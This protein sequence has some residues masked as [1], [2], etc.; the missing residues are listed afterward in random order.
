MRSGEELEAP[1]ILRN[2]VPVEALYDWE[3]GR[4]ITLRNLLQRHGY[5]SLE[6][7]RAEGGATTEIETLR[8]S[9]LE[10]LAARSLD[11]EDDCRA[12]IGSC[13]NV[14]VLTRWL[15]RAATVNSS[16]DVAEPDED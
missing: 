7:V 5:D 1:G 2:P 13:Q 14:D 8:R 11:A 16:A 3:V 15:R 12:M 10:V 6:A 9:I 4:E